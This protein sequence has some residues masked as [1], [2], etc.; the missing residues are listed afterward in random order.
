MGAFNAV[1]LYLKNMEQAPIK[2]VMI[3][4]GGGMEIGKE[5]LL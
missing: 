5:G 2:Q 1:L 4:W 3:R